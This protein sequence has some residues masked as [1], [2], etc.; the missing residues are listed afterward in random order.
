[1]LKVNATFQLTYIDFYHAFVACDVT[2][3]SKTFL[4]SKFIV[5]YRYINASFGVAIT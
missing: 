1:M 2:F 3:I 5:Y 4:E